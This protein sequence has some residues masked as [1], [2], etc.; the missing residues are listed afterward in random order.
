MKDWQQETFE[1]FWCA[2]KDRTAPE[3]LKYLDPRGELYF[4]LDSVHVALETYKGLNA[5]FVNLAVGDGRGWW[6]R[7]LHDWLQRK[8][9]RRMYGAMQTQTWGRVLQA[10]YGKRGLR[11]EPIEGRPGWALY[12][13]CI[14]AEQQKTEV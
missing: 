8:G 10:R 11:F 12:E 3:L 2:V 7:D 4:R 9:V 13:L 6:V 5:V 14:P 1:D